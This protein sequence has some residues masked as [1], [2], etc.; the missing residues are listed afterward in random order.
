MIW[1]KLSSADK[2][3]EFYFFRHPCDSRWHA[4]VVTCLLLGPVQVTIHQDSD[5][6]CLEVT[7]KNAKHEAT[8]RADVVDMSFEIIATL[9]GEKTGDLHSFKCASNDHLSFTRNMPDMFVLFMHFW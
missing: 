7:W 6:H 8:L 2:P 1:L 4:L 9:E 5:K 3:Y